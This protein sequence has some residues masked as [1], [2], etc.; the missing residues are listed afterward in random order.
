M[1][2][3]GRG[4]APPTP[5]RRPRAAPPYES[6]LETIGGTPMVRL[7]RV[8]PAGAATVFAKLESFEPGGSVKDRI[9]LAMIEA[10]EGKGRLRPGGALV[11]PTSGNTG[12]G[13]ALVCAVKGYR[14]SLVM[15]DSTALEHRQALEAY[16]ANVVLTRA[17]DG[18]EAAVSRARDLARADGALLLDQF[19]NLANPAAHLDGT[20][21]ELVAALRE[22][23]VTP[24]AFVAGVGTGGTLSGVAPVLR[25]A[26]PGVIVVAVE[27]EACAVLSG[28]P[29]GP[30]RVQG[31]GAGFVPAVLDRSAYDR[32]L[33]VS[34]EDAWAMKLRLAR[35]EGL[36][37]GV[38][39]GAAAVAAA[40]VAAELGPDDAVVTLLAD[41]GERYFSMEAWFEPVAEGGR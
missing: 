6:I 8:V 20:G 9:A 21:P 34:D 25:R 28:G 5:A 39:S 22:A 33:T 38:S 37:V 24:G 31:L 18:M 35:E 36:L 19:A 12:I 41:T 23:G 14:L 40:R 16:G 3:L 10:A 11:E 17:E 30:T 29:P 26:F 2:E 13:L 4:S 32:V 7:H 15:P 1:D 27:P